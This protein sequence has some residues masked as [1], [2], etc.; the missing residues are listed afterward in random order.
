VLDLACGSGRHLAV[1][2]RTNP[3]AFG[4]DLSRELLD[5]AEPELR[6]WLLRGDMRA[7]P[8]R[9]ASLSG[10][11]LWFTPFGY[12]SDDENRSLLARLRDLLAPGGVLVLDYLNAIH[13]RA[14]LVPEDERVHAGLRVVSRRSVEDH[15]VVKR[16]V[17]THLDTGATR[18]VTESVRLYETG[19]LE[20]MARGCGLELFLTA[21][22]Y[23]GGPFEPRRSS[24]WIGFLRRNN[25]VDWDK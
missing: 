21:G 20:A 12:F 6:P 2:R 4:L 1:L 7:L 13:V 23:Q 14:H 19:D 17:L 8:F 24:R 16:M 11:C 18:K 3:Q 22:D 15:R 25:V 10:I 5:L 9:P